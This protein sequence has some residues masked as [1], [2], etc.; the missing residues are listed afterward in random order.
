MYSI[1]VK[2]ACGS[3]LSLVLEGLALAICSPLVTA[4]DLERHLGS[5]VDLHGAAIVE[6]DIDRLIADC[7]IQGVDVIAVEINAEQPDN[8]VIAVGLYFIIARAVGV[9]EGRIAFVV[10]DKRVVFAGEAAP[11]AVG[12]RRADDYV[13]EFVARDQRSFGAAHVDIFDVGVSLVVVAVQA[14][15]TSSSS[16]AT[17]EPFSCAM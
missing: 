9:E 4:L 8:V 11:Q 17:I 6:L 15:S 13:L 14:D 16:S 7:L 5:A 10:T 2:S 3:D 12:A 1:Q